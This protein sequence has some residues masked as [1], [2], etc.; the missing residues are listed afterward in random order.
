MVDRTPPGPILTVG[1]ELDLEVDGGRE[2]TEFVADPEDGELKWGRLKKM[3]NTIGLRATH[4]LDNLETIARLEFLQLMGDL[5]RGG[6]HG[7]KSGRDGRETI[8]G[9]T[10][11]STAKKQRY[12][13]STFIND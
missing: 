3:Q 12:I 4:K 2:E 9:G 13:R 8:N 5:P 7:G 6:K 1:K 10:P 11:G